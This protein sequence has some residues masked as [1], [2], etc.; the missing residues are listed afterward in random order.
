MSRRT[1][2]GVIVLAAGLIFLA[3]CAAK[4][5]TTYSLEPIIVPSQADISAARVAIFTFR[6]PFKDPIADSHLAHQLHQMLL[7]RRV[8]RVIEVLPEGFADLGQA[9]DRARVLGYDLAVLGQVQE[10]F[11][12]G[13]I[14][15]TKTTVEL[16][17]VDVVRKVTIWYFRATAEDE[18]TPAKDYGLYRTY[19]EQPAVPMDLIRTSLGRMADEL[20]RTA[21]VKPVRPRPA[22]SPAPKGST[23]GEEPQ[24]E[25]VP[26]DEEPGPS[27]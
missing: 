10:A 8:A 27:A 23:Q 9:I 4:V 11:Y 17:V 7:E 12:G 6:T 13:E 26:P 24:A 1:I 16:R 15:S 22:A 25:R 21:R 19:S 2:A 20:A 18:L 14:G 3:G 5:K